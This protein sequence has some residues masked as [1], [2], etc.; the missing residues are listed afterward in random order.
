MIRSR[1]ASSRAEQA[2]G[3][4]LDLVEV[5]AL[6]HDAVLDDLRESGAELTVGQ[7]VGRRRDRR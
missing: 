4:A 3:V 2:A 1:T 7:R 5:R 6:E